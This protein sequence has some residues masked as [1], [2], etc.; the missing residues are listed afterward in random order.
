M[1]LKMIKIKEITC[2]SILSTSGIPGIDYAL[3]PYVGCEHGCVYCYAIFMKRFTGH[4]EPWGDFVDVK[5]NAP[6]ILRK[7]LTKIKPGKISIS[8]VTDGYQPLEEKYK[9]TRSCL[10]ELMAYQYPVSI[11]TKSSLIL[12]DLELLKKIKILDVGI[13]ITTL[14]E[15]VRKVLEPKS[16]SSIERLDTLKK[17]AK[18]GIDT[19]AFFAPVLPY[20]SDSVDK[21]E[22]LWIAFSKAEVRQVLVDTTNLYPKVYSNIKRVLRSL[23]PELIGRYE[24]IYRNR[25]KYQEELRWRVEI[26]ARKYNIPY[27]ICF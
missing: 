18:E 20:F 27:E 6:E 25:F 2:K 17:L 3:N 16:S 12:R 4:N 26:V 5:V 10:K 21:I 11:L 15:E 24:N 8:T 23:H 13:T 14:D 19:W 7:Q 1:I 9:I 22:E